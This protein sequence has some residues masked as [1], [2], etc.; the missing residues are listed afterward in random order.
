LESPRRQTQCSNGKRYTVMTSS[1]AWA[2]LTSPRRAKLKK[3]EHL[4]T[5]SCR[6][7]RT[8]EQ[9]QTGAQA[10]EKGIKKELGRCIGKMRRRG[11][12]PCRIRPWR[13]RAAR[14]GGNTR[15]GPAAEPGS[16]GRKPPRGGP[17]R[18]GRADRRRGTT[19]PP[20]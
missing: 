4:R 20:S 12:A 3:R 13:R 15:G 1:P 9:N 10:L 7:R 18:G 14:G 11:S 8:A 6:R 5:S 19:A 16:R 2:V 17:R